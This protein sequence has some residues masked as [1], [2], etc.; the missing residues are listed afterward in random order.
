MSIASSL[1]ADVLRTMGTYGRDMTV[2]RPV[3]GV[4]DPETGGMVYPSGTSEGDLESFHGRGRLG[5][6]RDA[7]VDGELIKQNDRLCTIVMTDTAFVP[8]VNHRLTVGEDT[9]VIQNVKPREFGGEWICFSL[10]VRR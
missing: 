8:E 4:Y 9:Y 6:Y 3:T 7:L 2:L 10:Q 1:R 5:T